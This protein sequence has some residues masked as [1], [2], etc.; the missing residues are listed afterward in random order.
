MVLRCS[1]VLVLMLLQSGAS[2][3]IKSTKVPR[4]DA[5]VAKAVSHIQANETKIGERDHTLVSYALL[6]AGLPTSE[7]IVA[8]GIAMARGRAEAVSYQ[9]YDHIYLAGVDAML[10]ADTE[11]DTNYPAIQKISDY[12]ASVQ[13]ADGSWSDNAT[14]PGDVSM[15]QYG[16]LALWAAKRAG[17]NVSPRALDRAALWLTRSKNSDGGWGYRPGTTAGPGAG[18]STHNMTL[19]GAGSVAVVRTLIHG[20]KDYKPRS[21]KRLPNSACCRKSMKTQRT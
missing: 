9:G 20:P 16:V 14:E 2:G 7:K 1:F 11:D 18:K 19:A 13:R 12:V 3:A 17:A 8:E 6:K 15:T 21:R 4:F 10:L 5:A